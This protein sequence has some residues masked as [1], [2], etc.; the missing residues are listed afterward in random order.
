MYY[1]IL[2]IILYY[3]ILVITYMQDIHNYTLITNHVTRTHS[4]AAVLYLHSV[5]I[6][7]VNPLE[8]T[9]VC[10]TLL[11]IDAF[12]VNSSFVSRWHNMS[13]TV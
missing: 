11:A 8:H 10:E 7:H 1:F 3:I 12:A 9:V 2:Y 6:S 13:Y 4:I 5:L